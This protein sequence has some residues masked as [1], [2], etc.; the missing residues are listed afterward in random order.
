MEYGSPYKELNSRKFNT[1]CCYKHRIDTYGLGCQ[2]DCSYCYAKGLLDFRKHWDSKK[3][4][5][6]NLSKIKSVISKLPK[7]T[8]IRLGSMT[9]C[10]QPIEL[11]KR[12]TYE[13]IKLLNKCKIHYL[14]VTKSHYVANDEYIEIYD[15]SLAHF[16]V[17][18]TNTNDNDYFKFE[19]ASLPSD[20]IKSI[21]LLYK[22]GYDISVRLSPFIDG[23]VD[24]KILNSIKCNKILVEFLKVNHW[25]KKWLDIDY[26]DYLVSY[27]GYINLDL[28][29]KLILLRNIKN[30]DQISV[31]EY[32][33][34]HYIY[35]RDNIN[36]N[37]YD[38]CN[39]DLKFNDYYK[40]SELWV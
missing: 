8:V 29:K 10:F 1:W 23:W 5:Q 15:K 26:S 13:T 30:F 33:K 2:H 20:R 18:I 27:G 11:D 22:L 38:C 19:K 7:N 25:V 24:Y 34:N 14:I 36:Y 4:L 21:E 31:G 16:Q 6:S 9:D 40:Q 32:V 37:R 12:I 28:K 3:P 35:F 39:L 17:S